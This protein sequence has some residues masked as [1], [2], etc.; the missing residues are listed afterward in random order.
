MDFTLNQL[1]YF[2][3]LARTGNFGRAAE[4]LNMSQPPLS[5]QIAALERD[6]GT[7]LFERTPKGVDL[8]PAGRQF[9]DDASAVLHLAAQAKGNATAAGRG[10]L[11]QLTVGFTM[12][13]AYSVVPAL[14]RL[15]KRAF[16]GVDFRVRE[17]MPNALRDQLM[18]GAIDLAINFPGI[19]A[20]DFEMRPL[21]R[22][23]L[24]A[25]LPEHH[26][27]ARAEGLRVE[28]LAQEQFLITPRQM[29]PALHDSIVRRCQAAGFTPVI[30]L[31]VYLQQTIVNF[32]AEGLG[33][34]FVPASMRRSNIK[35]AVFREI[36][37]PPTIDQLLFWSPTNRNPCIA[38]FLA[39]C[40]Q[41]GFCP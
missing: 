16:P 27:L 23:P 19:D 28:D 38:G 10:E 14:T 31:E 15:Y 36:D 13:A 12:C 33:V 4:R 1:R 26:P 34:A 25:V 39:T 37:D 20:M 21:L 6:L 5:R 2:C 30:G 9:L 41:P 18:T 22:E 35:G 40:R 32:V 7:I 17:V 11:G 29:A 3:E 24:S 8:T